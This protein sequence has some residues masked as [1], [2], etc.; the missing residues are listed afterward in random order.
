MMISLKKI[1]FV[2]K[3]LVKYVIIEKSAYKIMEFVK[4]IVQQV[5]FGSSLFLR[6]TSE[7]IFNHG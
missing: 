6:I 1:T 2:K 3:S 4:K 5:I 7:K